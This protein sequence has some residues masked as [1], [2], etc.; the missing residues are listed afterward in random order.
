[1]LLLLGDFLLFL[2]QSLFASSAVR[3]GWSNVLMGNFQ[4]LLAVSC[5]K[6]RQ[7]LVSHD[8]AAW[9][10][11]VT[12]SAVTSEIG[13]SFKIALPWPMLIFPTC[14]IALAGSAIFCFMAELL[15]STALS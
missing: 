9:P 5:P 10:F 8:T 14:G 12:V 13:D 15:T 3:F 4:S 2:L 11:M 7:P 1:M 6:A